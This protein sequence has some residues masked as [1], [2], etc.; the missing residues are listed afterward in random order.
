MVIGKITG[1]YWSEI[2]TYRSER[3]RII[4]VRRSR[5]EEV[6]IYESA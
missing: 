2:I 5:K 3:I 6:D 4:S 1:R